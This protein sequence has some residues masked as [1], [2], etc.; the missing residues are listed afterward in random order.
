[1][2]VV[3][4]RFEV[5]LALPIEYGTLNMGNVASGIL[6]YDEVDRM[7]SWQ[8]A[9]LLLGAAI[10]GCDILISRKSF[11]PCCPVAK[12]ECPT[13]TTIAWAEQYEPPR[14]EQVGLHP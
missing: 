13:D 2:R 3:F 7:E 14:I 8:L 5:T 10:I 9:L 6:F 1:M 4:Q 12:S 11:L